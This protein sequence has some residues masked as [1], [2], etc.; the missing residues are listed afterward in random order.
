MIF[1]THQLK[2]SQQQLFP[3][4]F[5]IVLIDI[6]RRLVR[7]IDKTLLN[8]K[9]DKFFEMVSDVKSNTGRHVSRHIRIVMYYK[10][11]PGNII[12]VTRQK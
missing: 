7:T 8:F 9:S 1:L 3:S 2:L 10:L 5:Y 11:L 4:N 12:N 6:I